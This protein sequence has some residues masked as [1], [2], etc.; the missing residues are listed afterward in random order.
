M[1]RWSKYAGSLAWLLA[2]ACGGGSVGEPS[3][4]NPASPGQS[5]DPSNPDQATPGGGGPDPSGQTPGAPGE[6]PGSPTP[7]GEQPDSPDEPSNPGPGVTPSTPPALSCSEAALGQPSL[8]LLTRSEFENTIN[9]IFPQLAGQWDNALPSNTVSVH[10][11]ANDAGATVGRQ[12]ADG[13]LE[14]AESIGAA[15]AGALNNLLPCA[16]AA[17]QACA[18]QFIADYGRRL[19][20]RPLTTEEQSRYSDFFVSAS[21]QTDFATAIKWVAAGLIQS[22]HAVYRSELG[23]VNGQSRML[24]PHEV[25]TELAYTFTGT[26]PSEELLSRADSGD[27]GDPVEVARGMLETEQGRAAL[28]RFF[29][30]HTGYPGAQAK[31]KPN[32][33]GNGVAYGDVS[34]DMVEE[35]RAFIDQI[36]FDQGG[37]WADLLTSPT[38]NPSSRLSSFYGLQAPG[39]DYSSVERPH[40][41]GLLAQGS[42]LATHANSDASSPTQRGVFVYTKLLCQAKPPVPDNVPQ[43]PQVQPGVQTTRQRYEDLHAGADACASCHHLFDPIGFAFENFDEAGRYREMEGN[44]PVDASG[45]YKTPSGADI[46]FQNLDDLALGLAEDQA[47]QECLTAYLATYAFGTSEACL[48]SSQVQDLQSGSIGVVEAFARLAAEPHFSQR[49]AQ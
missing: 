15:I 41:L 31:S 46:A 39:S 35:T 8:R 7:T 13:L 3:D 47:V 24:T 21:A 2:V 10:G 12:Q 22:P 18:N 5:P 26:T 49:D 1:M 37:G 20:R 32:A 14:T 19:F 27:L 11:F 6:Q 4:D 33:T 42:F 9:D 34:A 45:A 43:L 40:G 30:A 29:E 44:L 48:G 28:H 17:D 16:G 38:T 23:Q 25:A 36:L